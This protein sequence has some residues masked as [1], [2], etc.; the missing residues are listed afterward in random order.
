MLG[1]NT[2]YNATGGEVAGEVVFKQ[3]KESL[4]ALPAH[5][6]V[7]AAVLKC[8][9]M[10]EGRMDAADYHLDA[11]LFKKTG[12]GDDLVVIGAQASDA[13]DGDVVLAQDVKDALFGK[14][15]TQAVNDERAAAFAFQVGGKAGKAE[16]R[17]DEVGVVID[18][19]LTQYR[20]LVEAFAWLVG[21]VFRIRAES[22]QRVRREVRG[23]G[24]RPRS[25]VAAVRSHNKVVARRVADAGSADAAGRS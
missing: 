9:P 7:G 1:I 6:E 14:A 2:L 23:A 5:N 13:G 18:A 4:F 19:D 25:K 10:Q 11:V 8:F 17:R 3:F 21:W 24:Q 16:L 22:V 15:V 12:E 20:A